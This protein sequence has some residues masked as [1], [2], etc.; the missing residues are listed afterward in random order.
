MTI[1][2]LSNKA[3]DCDWQPRR[4][5][6]AAGFTLI[7]LLVVIAIIAILAAMLLPALSRAKSEAQGAQ[8]KSNIHQLAVAWESYADDN[9]NYF[10][11]N[12]DDPFPLDVAGGNVPTTGPVGWL[13]GAEGWGTGVYDNTNVNY[14]V[15]TP[16]GAYIA[17]QYNIVHCPGDQSATLEGNQLLPRL[18]SISMNGFVGQNA[19]WEQDWLVYLKASDL[20]QPGPASLLVFMDE[21]PDSIN[22][23]W[24]MFAQQGALDDG[25]PIG[26]GLGNG[27]WFNLPASYHNGAC[28]FSFADGH[29]ETRRWMS[30]LMDKP[31]TMQDYL[32]GPDVATPPAGPDWQYFI[33][34][35]SYKFK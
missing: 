28:N 6:R 34:H 4:L 11:Y 29:A 1:D 31:M 23:G 8:C 25:S 26:A 15:N 22:D 12:Y 33:H 7:E 17:K 24:C 20:S 14:I 16:F 32:N 10:V 18:R 27:D 5:R 13:Y 35:A 3:M 21:Q 9:K 2:S 30:T 19:G